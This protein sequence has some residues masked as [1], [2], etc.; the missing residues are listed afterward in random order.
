[1]TNDETRYLS[2]E[3]VEC[4]NSTIAISRITECLN[5]IFVNVSGFIHNNKPNK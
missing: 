3:S 4:V 5:Q 2:I 1:M